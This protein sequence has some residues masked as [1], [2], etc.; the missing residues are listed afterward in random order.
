MSAKDVS[1]TPRTVVVAEDEALIRMDLVEMLGELGYEVVGQAGDGERAVALARQL[2][3]DVVFLDVAMPTRDGLSAAEEI[4]TAKLAPVVM[5]TAFSQAEV[6]AKAASAGA[7]GYLVKP[8]GA[9]D[10]TPAIELA[11]AR[12]AQLQELEAQVANLQERVA[13]REVV[14]RAKAWLQSELGLTEAAAFTWLRRQATDGRLTW[15]EVAA[16]VLADTAI[17][18]PKPTR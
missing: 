17:A 9:S 5:V 11:I 2:S 13:A 3:P 1:L 8:F 18:G 6:V 7:L 16:R 12:W 4:V 10:L 15:A 14:E